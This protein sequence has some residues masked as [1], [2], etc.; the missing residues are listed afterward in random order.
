MVQPSA[1]SHRAPDPAI[2]QPDS[3]HDRGTSGEQVTA[4]EAVWVAQLLAGGDDPTPQLE[5]ARAL[6]LSLGGLAGLLKA[7]ME[8]GEIES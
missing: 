2:T 6:L 1:R 4:G 3:P 5:R 7:F 8:K